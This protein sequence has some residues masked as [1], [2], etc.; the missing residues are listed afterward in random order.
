MHVTYA[1]A[2]DSYLA[3]LFG[4]SAIV[5]EIKSYSCL[6]YGADLV[7]LSLGL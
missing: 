3:V 1:C 6:F 7:H 4:C 5:A 2:I